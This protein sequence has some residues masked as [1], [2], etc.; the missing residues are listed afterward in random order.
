[1]HLIT[2]LMVAWLAGLVEFARLCCVAP[3][4]SDDDGL[5]QQANQLC[6]TPPCSPAPQ[7]YG[8]GQKDH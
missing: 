7:A 3:V 6:Q 8:D 5:E 4:A 2:I 1:M